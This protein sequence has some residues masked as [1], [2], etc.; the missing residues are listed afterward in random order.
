MRL[1][2]KQILNTIQNKY[3]K[4]NYPNIYQ[5]NL[6]IDNHVF[7]NMINHYC[8][9]I[10][11]HITKKYINNIVTYNDKTK[12]DENN[13]IT[14]NYNNL[15]LDVNNSYNICKYELENNYDSIINLIY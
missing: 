4:Y 6:D 13:L 3:D 7:Q 15:E 11:Q 2:G 5:T 12:E 9:N 8:K 10:N 1:L 14:I